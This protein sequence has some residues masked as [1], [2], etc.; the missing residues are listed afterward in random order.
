MARYKSGRSSKEVQLPFRLFFDTACFA[1]DDNYCRCILFDSRGIVTSTRNQTGTVQ[2]HK[3]NFAH[4]FSWEQSE[5]NGPQS[6]L[7]VSFQLLSQMLLDGSIQAIKI[8]KPT[9][10]IG[11]ATQAKAFNKVVRVVSS[12]S[13]LTVNLV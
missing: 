9:A 10:L 12:F 3:Q 11:S 7:E 6:L 1:V 8:L 4:K 5:N 13:F 2:A